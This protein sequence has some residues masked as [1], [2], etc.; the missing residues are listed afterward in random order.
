ME[1]VYAGIPDALAEEQLDVLPGFCPLSAQK[2][3]WWGKEFS[4]KAS[5][6]SDQ[7]H[8]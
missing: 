6:P 5:E 1:N 2:P 7:G 4:D 3:N 8:A